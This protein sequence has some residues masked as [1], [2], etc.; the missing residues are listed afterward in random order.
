MLGIEAGNPTGGSV[1]AIVECSGGRIATAHV[2]DPSQTRFSF[3][4]IE[5]HA[6]RFLRGERMPS[7]PLVRRLVR[8]PRATYQ[9]SIALAQDE[10]L[11]VIA[12]VLVL[13]LLLFLCSM[14]CPCPDAAARAQM[15][16]QPRNAGGVAAVTA[17]YGN[18][19]KQS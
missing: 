19:P 18:K 3:G 16:H 8:L 13:S 15:M 1:F 11:I 4:A 12:I 17:R 6:A 7:L 14:L 2:M 5:E 9:A 10:P